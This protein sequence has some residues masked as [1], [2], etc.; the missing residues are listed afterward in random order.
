M[1][2]HLERVITGFVQVIQGSSSLHAV[3]QTVRNNVHIVSEIKAERG[4]LNR[5]NL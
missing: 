4:T 3:E 5:E 1:F 2:P